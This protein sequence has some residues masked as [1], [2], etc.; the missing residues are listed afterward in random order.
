MSGIVP[1]TS[2]EDAF[3]FT[4]SLQLQPGV[5]FTLP[6]T[7]QQDDVAGFSLRL[8]VEHIPTQED[9]DA[10]SGQFQTLYDAL[11]EAQKTL[12]AALI[13][14]AAG[15]AESAWAAGGSDA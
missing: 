9:A 10:L 2:N 13:G 11:P 4:I 6:L 12:M 7:G 8:P 1:G 14:Q 5:P 15:Y 3:P